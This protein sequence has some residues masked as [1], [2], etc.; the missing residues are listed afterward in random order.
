VLFRSGHV[1]AEVEHGIDAE[2]G[3]DAD[4]GFLAPAG[5]ARE[6]VAKLNAE[7]IKVLN[8]PEI[9]QRLAV[10]E[11]EPPA[12]SPPCPEPADRKES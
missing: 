9:T 7:I 2:R 11:R 10:L 3:T 4:I 5:T 6:I 12:S 8:T 1:D